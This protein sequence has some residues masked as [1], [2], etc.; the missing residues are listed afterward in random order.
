VTTVQVVPVTAWANRSPVITAMLNP[1]LLAAVIAIAAEEYER[2][3]GDAMPWPL[4]FLVAPLVLHRDTREALPRSTR[5]HLSRWVSSNPTLRA[6]FPPRA[7]SLAGPVREGLRFGLTE[8]ALAVVD[9]G[10]L[11][12]LLGG[13]TRPQDVGD[14]RPIVRSAGHVGKWFAKLDQAATAFALLGVAP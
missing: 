2:A 8:G 14:L 4:A 12:G 11:R 9:E 6:G 7:R 1:A 10:R 5:S 13:T 3:D